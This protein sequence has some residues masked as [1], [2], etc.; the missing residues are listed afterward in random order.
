MSCK[1]KP[2]PSDDIAA[3]ALQVGQITPPSPEDGIAAQSLQQCFC[4]KSPTRVDCS[5]PK[6]HS[7]APQ[8][9]QW[10]SCSKCRSR[11]QHSSIPR[12]WYCSLS[13]LMAFLPQI[14]KLGGLLSIARA[15]RQSSI[16]LM[17]FLLQILPQSKF[18]SIP[19]AW[20]RF[21]PSGIIPLC[22][23]CTSKRSPG[24]GKTIVLNV[25]LLWLCQRQAGDSAH[26]MNTDEL[27]R[28]LGQSREFHISS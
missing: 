15:Q 24:Q 27:A 2:R 13:S 11:A 25:P 28:R 4:P 23:A 17:V 18:C 8:D 26:A 19:R 21:S 7:I 22:H 6:G 16:S 9:P 12:E 20:H 5:P 3:P 10:Y 1:P 14:S